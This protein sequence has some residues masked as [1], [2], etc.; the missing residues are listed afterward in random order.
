MARQALALLVALVM[1][2]PPVAA[3]A[4]KDP[5]VARGIKLAEDG[6]YD[7]AI[8]TLDKAARRLAPDSSRHAELAQAYLYLG[9]AFVGKGQ[10]VAAKAKFRE[11][12]RQVRDLSLSAESFPPKVINLFEQARDEVGRDGSASASTPARAPAGSAGA[13]AVPS[14]STAPARKGGSKTPFLIGGGVILAGGA[15]ALAVG[16]GGGNGGGGDEG[17][18]TSFPNQMVNR[19]ADREFGV[20]VKGRGTLTARVEW[21]QDQSLLRMS[22]VNLAS[23]TVVLAEGL[24]SG[25]KEV[26]LSVPVTAGTYRITIGVVRDIVAYTDLTFTLTVIHP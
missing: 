3:Q 23:P 8:M 13:P 2:A 5:E 17:T 15:V 19:F 21:V 11:A 9:I 25:G 6:D 1:T 26:S 7:A 22:I 12:V 24:Q 10:E 14:S 16:G 20:D 4:V 18:T